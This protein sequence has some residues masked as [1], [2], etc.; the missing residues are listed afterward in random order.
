MP[1]PL[2]LDVTVSWNGNVSVKSRF[3]ELE[4]WCTD[5]GQQNTKRQWPYDQV[6]CDIVL[7]MQHPQMRFRP[8]N[9]W[10][11]INKVR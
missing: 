6:V 1:L 4:T 10:N 11:D 8:A 7:G 9:D 5:I 2:E 3:I